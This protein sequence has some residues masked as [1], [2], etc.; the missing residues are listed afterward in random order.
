MQSV[1]LAP[2]KRVRPPHRAFV[3]Q[4]QCH[5][6]EAS[7]GRCVRLPHRQQKISCPGWSI[8]VNIRVGEMVYLQP[9]TS[10]T[11][12]GNARSRFN[13]RFSTFRY[14]RQNAGTQRSASECPRDT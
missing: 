5:S 8:A 9:Q 13:M 3:M 12:T 2:V 6:P 10:V 11:V 7:I 4:S 1:S 14:M